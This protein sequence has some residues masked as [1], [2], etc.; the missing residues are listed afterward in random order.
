MKSRVS[1]WRPTACYRA[2]TSRIPAFPQR[3][4]R[5][6]AH[7]AGKRD[8]GEVPFRRI[9]VET[10][11]LADPAP[12]VQLLLIPLGN[13]P[14][15]VSQFPKEGR[16]L[17]RQSLYHSTKAAHLT[18]T[19]QAKCQPGGKHAQQETGSGAFRYP[20]SGRPSAHQPAAMME[21]AYAAVL[22]MSYAVPAGVDCPCRGAGDFCRLLPVR[23]LPSSRPRS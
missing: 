16:G 13:R 18:R 23:C 22:F 10:T 12:S 15:R 9:L 11:G 19:R 1:C 14:P 4:R 5:N 2:G 8:R 21:T 6:A 20:Q 3:P 17:R 7:T